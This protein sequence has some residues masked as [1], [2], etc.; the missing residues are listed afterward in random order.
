MKKMD[1]NVEE[2]MRISLKKLTFRVEGEDPGEFIGYDE[3]KC[4]GC[5]ACVLVCSAGLWAA[6]EGEKARLSGRYKELCLECGACYATCEKDAIS[7]RYPDGGA[8][9]VIKHG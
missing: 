8:G 1:F 6:K 2:F 4:N 7:F 5:G 9:I 3:G